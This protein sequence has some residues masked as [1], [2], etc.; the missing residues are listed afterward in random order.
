MALLT[1]PEEGQ[2]HGGAALQVP[3][4]CCE[5]AVPAAP[6]TCRTVEP[7]GCRGEGR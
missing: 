5:G 7:A 1:L 6:L 2:R 4:C 3:V